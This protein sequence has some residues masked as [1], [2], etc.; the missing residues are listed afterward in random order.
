MDLPTQTHVAPL[1]I[2]RRR[3]ALPL[4]GTI[5]A[6]LNQKVQAGDLIG[7]TTL[8]PKH[9]LIDVAH[10]LGVPPKQADQFFRYKAGDA[11]SHGDILAGPVGWMRRVVRAP[12]GGR[13][14][15]QGEGRLVFEAVGEPFELRA[16]LPGVVV[17][18]E[19]ERSVTIETIGALVEAVW[20]NGREEVG[21]LRMATPS[22]DTELTLEAIDI[23]LR[24][25]IVVAGRVTRPDVLQALANLPVRGLMVG[26]MPA[27]LV[28]A[29]REAHFAL[30]LT[31]GFGMRPMNSAAFELLAT[32]VGRDASL[33][34]QPLNAWLGSRPEL[35]IPL[36]AVG[37][38]D[39]PAE[40]VAP[41]VGRR[42]RIIRAP[43]AGKVGTIASMPH[44]VVALPSGLL[45][46]CLEVELTEEGMVLVPLANVDILE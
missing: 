7:R 4:P 8:Y 16:G 21:V 37:T 17:G 34:A 23:G 42:V 11:V 20:G 3:R 31:D 2:V 43:Y 9:F 15:V 24:S 10:H 25:T 19:A 44:G 41:V 26:S 39:V 38:A 40:G 35:V 22:A 45:A 5:T 14:I 30:A 28:P 27:A 32:N 6:R 18:M 46:A 12:M 36:P 1:V 33:N 13:V 29:A